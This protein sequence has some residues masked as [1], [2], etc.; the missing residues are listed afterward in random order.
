MTSTPYTSI[1]PGQVWLD[2]EG[3]RIQAHGGS[4][5]HHEGTFYWYGENKERT[6]PGSE[7]WH[8][9]VRCY[10][11]TDLYNWEDLGVIIPPVEDDPASPLH[12]AQ[13]ADRPHIVRNTAGQWVCWIK[14]MTEAGPQESTV[15]VADD[16]LGPWTVVRTGLRPLGMSAGD[17][18]L[19]VDPHDGKGYY[20]FERPHSELICADLSPDLTDVTGYYSTHFP[21]GRPPAVREAPA[22]FTRNRL[23]Y[24]ITSG[25]T[26]YLPNPSEVAVAK[27]YHGPWTVL[28]DPHPNDPSRTSYC[29][30]VSSVFKHP[31]KKDLYI[32]VADRWL[33]GLMESPNYPTGRLSADIEHAFASYQPGTDQGLPP[34]F[35]PAVREVVQKENTSIA[36]YVWLP[37]RFDGEMVYLDWHEEWRVED[38]D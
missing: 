8:W 20:Y 29:S 34:S 3:K 37:L 31:H 17:F 16:L 10:R 5:L 2:T 12:P 22:H 7:I 19:V 32:A 28:G 6:T 25:T 13:K 18:D 4:V 30:Q 26:A 21:L 33:P 14:V 27:T 9:G 15:L 11:S 35:T 36:D 38:Y 23:H 1:H 24:L